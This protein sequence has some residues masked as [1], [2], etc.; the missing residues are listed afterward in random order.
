MQMCGVATDVQITKAF[1]LVAPFIFLASLSQNPSTC[2]SD[3][4]FPVIKKP[5]V[6]DVGCLTA[7]HRRFKKLEDCLVR[8]LKKPPT[9]Q[10]NVERLVQ[11]FNIFRSLVKYKASHREE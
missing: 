6:G 7:S 3:S 8:T 1:Q 10:I 2:R 4:C 9:Q 11:L 5:S